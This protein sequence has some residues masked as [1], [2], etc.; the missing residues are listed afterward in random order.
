MLIS[1]QHRMFKILLLLLA[2][3]QIFSLAEHTPSNNGFQLMKR[4]TYQYQNLP[5]TYNGD[6]ADLEK[7]FQ[8]EKIKA[9]KMLV[10]GG[11]TQMTENCKKQLFFSTLIRLLRYAMIISKEMKQK[12]QFKRE[13]VVTKDHRNTALFHLSNAQ[14]N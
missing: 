13:S 3:A 9:T 2:L 14:C 10:C 7:H 6:D 8:N 11:G 1:P 12:G 4:Y 5:P